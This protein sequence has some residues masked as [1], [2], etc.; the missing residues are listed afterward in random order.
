MNIK[1]VY[2]RSPLERA[3]TEILAKR[4]TP[5][6][7]EQLEKFF[8]ITAAEEALELS[9]L[10]K[11]VL[12][13]QHLDIQAALNKSS[14]K[15]QIN[16]RDSRGYTPLHWAVEKGNAIAV[17]ALL[18]SGADVNTVCQQRRT[19]LHISIRS[20]RYVPLTGSTNNIQ[21]KLI[22]SLLSAG[23]DIKAKDENG[24][25][26][27]HLACMTP[28]DFGLV[29]IL[30]E[31]GALLDER[32]R[33]GVSPLGCA[34]TMNFKYSDDRVS[35]NQCEIGA[36][37]IERG[38]SLNNRDNDGDTPLFQAVHDGNSS[39][40]KMLLSKGADYTITD[41]FGFTILHM[42][43]MFGDSNCA[44]VLE[45]V[46]LRGVDPDAKDNNGKAARQ[47]LHQRVAPPEGLLAAF[48]VLLESVREANANPIVDEVSE[49]T[50]EMDNTMED[51]VEEEFSEA[52]ETPAAGF[53]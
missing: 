35:R 26:A 46:K 5:E 48:E 10:H 37:L 16:S 11:V 8:P 41:N 39:F 43:A 38:V 28:A 34:A 1:G 44:Q 31:N 18:Q 53:P 30:V 3:W 40:A 6:E 42:T 14:Y 24:N 32:S 36:F 50:E 23:A 19:P 33:W 2:E 12:G 15:L 22:Q 13:L 25:Q 9:D 47:Y 17:Q 52:Q 49:E 4:R 7:T 21:H 51:D 45:Q 27:L 20:T 29:K